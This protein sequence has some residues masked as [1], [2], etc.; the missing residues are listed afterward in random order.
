MDEDHTQS[1]RPSMDDVTSEGTLAVIGGSD[2]TSTTI[3]VIIYYLLQSP[4]QLQQLRAEIDQ[5]F[6]RD[7]EPLDFARMTAMPYLNGCM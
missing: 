5:N 6:T 7:E 4:S 2:T 1:E 3:S